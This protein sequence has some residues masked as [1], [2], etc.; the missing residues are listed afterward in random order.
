MLLWY[1]EYIMKCLKCKIVI[2]V[3]PIYGL[4]EEC[5]I[6]SFG[7]QNSAK[8]QDLDPKKSSS[9]QSGAEI[10]KKV[11]TFFQGV[12]LKYSAKLGQ[13]SYILK[14]QEPEYPDLPAIEYLCNQIAELL[15]MDIPP[16]HLIN[17]NGRITF[18]T[19]NFMQ[20]YIGALQHIYKYLPI[21]EEN[22]NCEEIV[23]A[24]LN[25]TGKLADVAKFIDICLFDS[26]IGNN[27]RHGRNLGII[28]T[29]D[30]KKLSPVYDNPSFIGIQDDF[31]LDSD[32]NPSGCI[33]TKVSK[34]P[35]PQDYIEE[36][37][38]LGHETISEKFRKKII[39]Q[40]SNIINLVND[41]DLPA[42]R[43]NA[44]IRLIEKRM[45]DFRND[46]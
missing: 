32:T 9:K 19:R 31:L 40:S 38:R 6:A 28:E 25:N 42:K 13:V 16:Y 46:K 18:V 29:A 30:L 44:F 7:L 10:K 23:K 21:G 17:F 36:F 11:D 37:A 39:T 33:W 20:D 43:K 34:N 22:H 3:A 24:I 27:D 12:Y 15:G 5:F 8:F 1:I 35:K 45:R 41:S 2:D 14:I 4:H 26:L